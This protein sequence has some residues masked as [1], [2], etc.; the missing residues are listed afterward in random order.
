MTDYFALFGLTRRLELVPSELA[1]LYRKLSWNAHPD[2]RS[3]SEQAEAM[4]QT[5]L[6]NEA[7]RILKDPYSRVRHL[8]DLEGIPPA[9]NLPAA[10][11]GEVFE[12]QELL[13]EPDVAVTELAAQRLIWH[14]RAEVL[15]GQ[16]TQAFRGWDQGD[17]SVLQVLPVLLAQ[18]T[19]LGSI[20]ERLEQ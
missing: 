13:D 19:Y 1:V 10:F 18:H 11:L 14:D 2:R 4:G 6:L 16:F 7:Y 20:L 15:N 8:L 3:R 12:I 9:Q 5:A 17:R